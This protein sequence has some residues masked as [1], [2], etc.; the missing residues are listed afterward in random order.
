MLDCNT[1][2]DSDFS[3]STICQFWRWGIREC[4][5][6]C[7]VKDSE[8]HIQAFLMC[9][10]WTLFGWI[11]VFR[12]QPAHWQEW[13]LW[14]R[15]CVAGTDLCTTPIRAFTSWRGTANRWLGK[16]LLKLVRILLKPWDH[17]PEIFLTQTLIL[18]L[19]IFG[20]FLFLQFLLK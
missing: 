20:K 17:V 19:L 4:E 14:I 5:M 15:H 2:Q 1:R 13:R 18:P 16:F 6:V 8:E 9:I 3:H 10:T 7:L 11:Q 12:L